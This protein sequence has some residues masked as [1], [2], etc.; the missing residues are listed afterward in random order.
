M[1]GPTVTQIVE[2]G[3]CT[4]CGL[5]AAVVAQ[6]KIRIAFSSEGYLRPRVATP[7]DAREVDRVRTVCPGLSLAHAPTS[8]PSHPIW[9]PLQAVRSGYSTDPEIRRQGSSGGVVSAIALYLLETKR[10]DF[11]AQISADANDPIGNALQLSRT[12]AEVIRAAGSRYAPSSPLADLERLLATGQRFALVGKPCD[13]AAIRKLAS[14]DPRISQQIPYLLSFMCAGIPSRHGTQEVL[15]KM[16]VRST[17]KSFRYRGD[18]WPGKARAVTTDGS[19]HEMDY[20]TSWGTILNRHLQFRCKICP[21]GTG[22]FADIVCADAW[23]GKDGYPDFEEREGRSLILTR[24]SAGEAIIREALS[25]GSICAD[26]LPVEEIAK[27][28]PYQLKRKQMVLS[29]LVG[30]F[31]RHGHAPR[32][33]RLGLVRAAMQASVVDFARSLVGTFRRA[34][35]ER[36]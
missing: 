8:A 27:M 26:D 12:K 7:L 4:G 36:Q 31:F 20:S 33:H 10:V 1:S 19:T 32:F 14:I 34:R 15:D 29:R 30:T 23:Y 28:Q 25:T 24:T 21:D 13:V 5:C 17:L 18:G 9:G 2:R 22:E 11:I 35:K 16:G 3:L 6:G